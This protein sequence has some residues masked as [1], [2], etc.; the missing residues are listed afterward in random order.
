MGSDMTDKRIV[1]VV[2]D[3]PDN[4]DVLSGVLKDEFRVKAAVNGERALKIAQ[5]SPQPDMILL[6]VMMPGMD[7]YEVC[8]ALKANP[9]TSRIPVIFVTAKNQQEDETRGLALGAVDYITKPISPA[10]VL[11]RVHTHLNLY[12]QNLALERKVADRTRELRD[13]RYEVIRRLGR[14]AEFK[15][16]ETGMHVVRMSHFARLIAER[17]GA[18]PEWVELVFNASPMHDIGKIGIP[19]RVLLKPGK[20]DA[21]E[22]AIMQQHP[23]IGADIL[24]D[25]DSP[26][27][28]MARTI[29][30]YHHEKWD[31]TGYPE[32]L[33]GMAIPLE[34]RIVAIADVFDAVTSERPYKRA[35]A[36]GDAVKLIQDGAGTHFDPDLVSIFEAV[37]PEILQ[38]RDRYADDP[39]LATFA[40]A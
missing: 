24:G 1:L 40:S 31:G 4:I 14:A 12:D 35:W 32:G 23:V 3:T 8:Q 5:T 17:L 22:W 39:T 38:I 21:E 7:G 27:L 11:A 30:L 34:A 33:A 18:A 9:V 10:I 29:A 13:T 20:L 15:D 19:D 26:L 25:H 36:I 37:L 16:N 6:D 28:E 2:D